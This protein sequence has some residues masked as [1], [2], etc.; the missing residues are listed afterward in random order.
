[1]VISVFDHRWSY[2]TGVA[3]NRAQHSGEVIN[4]DFIGRRH[5]ID[6]LNIGQLQVIAL[7]VGCH[8]GSPCWPVTNSAN[9]HSDSSVGSNVGVSGG[10]HP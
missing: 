5:H 9:D 10:V 7:I 2:G 1:M 8:T 4:C 6:G 3:S